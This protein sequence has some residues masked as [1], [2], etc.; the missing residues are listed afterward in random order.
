MRAYVDVVY[1]RYMSEHSILAGEL[2]KTMPSPLYIF[3]HVLKTMKNQNR[4][5]T[6][7]CLCSA[8][9][10]VIEDVGVPI[11]AKWTKGLPDAIEG[12]IRGVSPNPYERK[13][14]VE[15]Y[16]THIL[17]SIININ[18]CS[19][20]MLPSLGEEPMQPVESI[21]TR[22]ASQ[23]IAE[24]TLVNGVDASVMN[25]GD[26]FSRI[27]TLQKELEG[28][29]SLPKSTYVTSRIAGITKDISDLVSLMDDTLKA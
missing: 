29:S 13:K 16:L 9:T 7:R 21:S 26:F 5:Y 14:A 25:E 19:E 27:H 17:H 3:N 10:H 1:K 6:Y 2:F 4:D 12:I 22:Y 20:I 18:P 24:V 23:N 15:D 8:A 28:L 11:G